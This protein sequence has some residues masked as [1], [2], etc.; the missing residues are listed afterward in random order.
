MT[1]TIGNMTNTFHPKVKL[2]SKRE[3]KLFGARER[4]RGEGTV[5]NGLRRMDGISADGGDKMGE[6]G[7]HKDK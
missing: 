4:L 6:E 2:E 5:L 3:T 7:F 1:P